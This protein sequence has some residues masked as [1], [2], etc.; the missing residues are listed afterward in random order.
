[1]ATLVIE[2]ICCAA[3]QSLPLLAETCRY[4][5]RP[6]TRLLSGAALQ[7][8]QTPLR[9]SLRNCKLRCAVL[10]ESG[11][12]A[13]RPLNGAHAVTGA[14]SQVGSVF[15]GTFELD[16]PEFDWGAGYKRPAIPPQDLVIYEMGVRS[17][18]ADASAGLPAADGGTFR[19]LQ[20]KARAGN[21]VHRQRDLWLESAGCGK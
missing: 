1:M 13:R 15:R 21:L 6:P 7:Q 5:T 2:V 14:G 3:R 16:E 8:H 19:G 17:F 4:V 9:T 11:W 12:V 18:T 20:A 10:A